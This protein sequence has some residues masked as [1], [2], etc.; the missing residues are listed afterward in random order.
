MHALATETKGAG[1]EWLNV[2]MLALAR[3]LCFAVQSCGLTN[4]AE[5]DL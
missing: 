1:E 2:K 3:G 5:F 4:R